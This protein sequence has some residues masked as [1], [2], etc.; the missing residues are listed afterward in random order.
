MFGLMVQTGWRLRR[1]WQ[2][3]GGGGQEGRGGG[4]Q[5]RGGG[6]RGGGR[7]GGGGGGYS[8]G[9]FNNAL[10]L[11]N[12]GIGARVV[13]VELLFRCWLSRD[14]PVGNLL[15]IGI[16]EQPFTASRTTSL[17]KRIAFD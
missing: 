17:S 14:G 9:G 15:D 8:N 5:F 2:G 4:R 16:C 10:G 12:G 11:N 1:V 3:G 7:G 13:T 6:G